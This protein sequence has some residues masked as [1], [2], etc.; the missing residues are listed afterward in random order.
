[1]W[2]V[3]NI[4]TN[5]IVIIEPNAS[6][7][8]R[9][10]AI[11]EDAISF[12]CCMT[13]LIKYTTI[14]H[15]SNRQCCGHTYLG[16]IFRR[17]LVRYPLLKANVIIIKMK[18]TSEDTNVGKKIC[19]AELEHKKNGTYSMR[20]TTISKTVW[21]FLRGWNK[22]FTLIIQLYQKKKINWQSHTYS[23]PNAR[24]YTSKIITRIK[25]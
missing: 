7:M 18:A 1:M 8:L 9:H 12:S 23:A 5:N 11:I 3:Y 21:T 14:L 10:A 25:E 13:H 4:W 22:I 16:T 15:T 2:S 19:W 17:I 6:P 24:Y 20:R